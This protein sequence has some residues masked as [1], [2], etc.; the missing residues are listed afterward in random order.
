MYHEKLKTQDFSLNSLFSGEIPFTG[1]EAISSLDL[2]D[3]LRIGR[4]TQYCCTC[5]GSLEMFN[6]KEER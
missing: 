2:C 3:H 1:G 5:S 4:D 6:E